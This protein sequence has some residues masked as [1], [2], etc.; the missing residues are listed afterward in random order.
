M[1]SSVDTPQQDLLSGKASPLMQATP[2]RTPVKEPGPAETAN[3][4]ISFTDSPAQSNAAF[5]MG[6]SVWL[7][8][9][10][11]FI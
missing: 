10:R 11:V 4:F 9:C 8:V 1:A 3:K 5:A 6:S 2:I 7:W